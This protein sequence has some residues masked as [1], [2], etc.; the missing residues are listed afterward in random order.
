MNKNLQRE[1]NLMDLVRRD[2]FL[3]IEYIYDYSPMA[4][5][6]CSRKYGRDC[7]YSAGHEDGRI[8]PEEI[9]AARLDALV[10][11]EYLDSGYTIPNKTKIIEAD[12]NE[13]PWDRRVPG[14][15]L[16]AKPGEQ[17]YIHVMNGDKE[18][19]HSFHLHGLKYGIDSDGA[20]PFGVVSQDGRQRSDEILPGQQWTYVFSATAETIGAWVFHDHV[21][22]V[23]QNV[24]R[25]LFGGLIIRDPYALHANHEIPIFIHQMVGVSESSQFESPR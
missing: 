17:L 2:I 18:E 5:V 9:F 4:P 7:M 20:W 13:P 25:G 23:Q 15:V 10:Y 21:R 14:T 11:H 12:V 24:N 22:N 19:C 8:P 6:I 3:K 16:Y 1:P